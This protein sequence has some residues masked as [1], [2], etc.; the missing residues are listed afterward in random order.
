MYRRRHSLGAGLVALSALTL[1]ILTR[2]GALFILPFF[3]LWLI[4]CFTRVGKPRLIV[5]GLATA[6]I[7]IPLGLNFSLAR[8]YGSANSV[9]AAKLCYTTGRL[10]IKSR[11]PV[12]VR[13][14]GERCSQEP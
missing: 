4:I 12:C 8:L 1:A 7:A 14:C 13:E 2:M 10:S 11:G 9:T 6:A 5:A 3:V